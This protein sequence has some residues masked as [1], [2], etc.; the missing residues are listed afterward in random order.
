MRPAKRT[1]KNIRQIGTAGPDTKIYVENSVLQFLQQHMRQKLNCLAALLGNFD[2]DQDTD[3]FYIQGVVLADRIH[4]KGT[5]LEFEMQAFQMIQEDME[6]F[7]PGLV[8]MGWYLP[9]AIWQNHMER[10]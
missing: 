2:R 10:C 9:I 5:R 6:T 1:L 4:L 8:M 3:I 7:F